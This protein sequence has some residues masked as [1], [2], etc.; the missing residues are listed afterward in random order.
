MLGFTKK[1]TGPRRELFFFGQ[2]IYSYRR[3]QS[4]KEKADLVIEKKLSSNFK[5]AVLTSP[6]S[7]DSNPIVS[8]KSFGDRVDTVYL[9]IQ[10]IFEQTLP[11]KKIILWLSQDEFSIKNLPRTLQECRKR[12]LD[13][14]FCQDYRSYDKLIHT[15][16]EYPNDDII[17][18]DDDVLYPPDL[19]KI[20]TR[21]SKQYPGC[22][23]GTRGHRITL[24]S[25]RKPLA[26]QH[27]DQCITNTT[28]RF[29]TLLTGTGG[30][31]YPTGTFSSAV[32]DS[33]LF[34][35][36]CPTGD[37]IWFKAHAMLNGRKSAI[38]ADNPTLSFLPA[39]IEGSQVD[40]LANN[41]VISGNDKQI[42]DTFEYYNLWD[43]LEEDTV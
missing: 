28:P 16:E 42:R 4:D 15:L 25:N 32:L 38:V 31:F 29:D 6:Q 41:N 39:F 10:S 43:Q 40:C 27:W 5:N 17:T 18:I 33:K 35:Q 37:D 24:D 8:L 30:I 19:L 21:A 11:A 23:L 1:R 14:R 3:H 9:T 12:G 20:L 13:V 2:R 7:I 34:M 26:Y 36:L 22:V